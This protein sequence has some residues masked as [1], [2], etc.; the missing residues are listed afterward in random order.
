MKQWWCVM[1]KEFFNIETY[2]LKNTIREFWERDYA[3]INIQEIGEAL[4]QILFLNNPTGLKF[5]NSLVEFPVQKSL[6]RIRTDVCKLSDVLGDIN[7]FWCLPK[8]KVREGRLNHRYEQILYASTNILTACT[9]TGVGNGKK[10]LL[11]EYKVIKKFLL[12]SMQLKDRFG[13]NDETAILYNDFFNKIMSRTQE[14]KPG[15]YKIT[16]Y[17]KDYLFK[18]CNTSGWLYES[19][20]SQKISNVAL[21][22]PQI[23]DKIR[24]KN[25]K[26]VEC[27]NSTYDVIEE[28]IF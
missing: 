6:F 9:E 25:V 20:Q 27:V 14:E 2:K 28:K 7:N 24:V 16:N 26:I 3:N 5:S 21:Q 23:K 8:E 11:I 12:I 22:Y 13:A 18:I 10:F 19:A 15:I 17:I 4:A 1:N